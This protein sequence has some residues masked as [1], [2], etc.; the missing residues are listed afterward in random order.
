MLS[1]AEWCS[2]RA[3]AH[4]PSDRTDEG[5]FGEF[6]RPADRVIDT[7]RKGVE[8]GMMQAAEAQKKKNNEEEFRK[9]QY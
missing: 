1:C 2:F 3:I 6:Y 7:I 4:C 5:V 8:E 9:E